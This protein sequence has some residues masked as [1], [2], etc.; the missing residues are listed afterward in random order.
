MNVCF[1]FISQFNFA[2]AR[3]FFRIQS[4]THFLLAPHVRSLSFRY[5]FKRVPGL[6]WTGCIGAQGIL[7]ACCAIASRVKLMKK[8]AT[9][10]NKFK[11]DENFSVLAAVIGRQKLHLSDKR[12]MQHNYWINYNISRMALNYVDQKTQTRAC[13][14]MD[15]IEV[16]CVS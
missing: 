12:L 8:I 10:M 16:N 6:M 7:H 13:H 11:C 2:G 1:H 9:S 4:N 5:I 14:E 3:H 15:W